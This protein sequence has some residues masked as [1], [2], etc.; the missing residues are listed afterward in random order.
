ME[1][2]HLFFFIFGILFT[3]VT[4]LTI[5]ISLVMLITIIYHW[6]PYCRST[7]NLLTCNSC[8]AFLFFSITVAIQIPNIFQVQQ[9][10]LSDSNLTTMSCR[11]RG[12]LLL[13]SCIVKI[14]SYLIQSISRYF[15][16][17]LYKHKVLLMYRT[18][19]LLIL[20]NWIS[21]LILGGPLWISP[22][23]F[24]YEPESHLCLFTSKA[25]NSSLTLMMIA[26]LLPVIIIILLYSIILKHTTHINSIHVNHVLRNAR[27]RNIKVYRNILLV[28]TVLVMAGTPY[29][30]SIIVNRIDKIPWPFYL[31]SI[32]SMTLSA[33]IELSIIFFTNH[34]VKRI[35]YQ[36]L[37]FPR[38]TKV[39]VL[40]AEIMKRNLVDQ[41]II[42]QINVTPI[43][44]T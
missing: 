34:E 19:I 24:Q 41:A 39:L 16:I 33:L 17:I 3:I 42:N 8:V 7:L 36:K 28:I 32:F 35:I 40:N 4:I 11:I 15:T 43:K 18:H 30:I 25:F 14:L 26:F 20:F 6:R 27:L 38:R 13:L 37:G 44:T 1:N 10:E 22:N 31:I 23:A 5:I 9:Q 2:I 29:L 12:F 21:S